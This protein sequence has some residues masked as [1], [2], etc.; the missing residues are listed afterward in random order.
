MNHLDNFN[1]N[2][3]CV[4]KSA[5]SEELR[6]FVTQYALF[7]EPQNFLPEKDTTTTRPIVPDAHY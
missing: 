6:D 3:Y 5:I 1:K 7:D 2:G 4:I